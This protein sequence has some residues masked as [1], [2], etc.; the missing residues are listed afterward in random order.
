MKADAEKY[1][2]EDKQKKEGIELRN[3]VDSSVYQ[4]EKILEENKEK[5]PEDEAK[6]TSELLE[7]VKKQLENTSIESDKLKELNSSLMEQLQKLAPH[8]QAEQESA[9]LKIRRTI[10]Y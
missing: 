7:D 4:I 10:Y 5:V 3:Q 9:Y 1:A 2:D 6:Q 8:M